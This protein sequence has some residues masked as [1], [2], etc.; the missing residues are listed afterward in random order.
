MKKKFPLSYHDIQR[1]KA[2]EYERFFSSLPDYYYYVNHLGEVRWMTE[3]EAGKQHEFFIYDESALGRWRRRL[4]VNRKIPLH[5]LSDAEREVRLRIRQYLAHKNL[6]KVDP[7]LQAQIPDEWKYDL[8]DEYLLNIPITLDIVNEG[9]WKKTGI[10]IGLLALISIIAYFTVAV[11][12][13]PQVGKVL[14]KTQGKVAG[15][16]VYMDEDIFLG[17]NNRVLENIPVGMHRFYAYKEG[18]ISLPKYHEVNIL[19]DSLTTLQ[20]KFE[21]ARSEVQGYLKI[22]ADLKDSKVFVDNTYLG[23]LSKNNI[24]ALEEGQHT[25]NVQKEGYMTKPAEKVV[26]IVVGDTSFV[27]LTQSPLPR[28][29]RS[30]G[31]LPHSGIGSIEITSN[32]KNARIYLNGKDTGY[33][34]DYIFT[35]F[36]LGKYTV[37]VKKD[38]FFV[39][40]E[41]IECRL[42]KRNPVASAHFRLVRKYERVQIV[43]NPEKGPI[44]IDDKFMGEGKFEGVLN[45]GEH[46]IHFG[47]IAG[48]KTPRPRKIT[49]SP[50]ARAT[51][52][53][54]YF[55]E[56]DIVASIDRSGRIVAKSCEVHTGYTSKYR[57]FTPS[58][59][60]GPEIEF[61]NLTKEYLMVFGFAFPY[62][63]PKGNDAIRLN[64]N[65]PENKDVDQKFY[66]KIYAA[67]SRKKY[68]FVFTP[69]H[70]VEILVKINDK[71]LSTR[72]KP[73]YLED[74]KGLAQT[75]WEITPFIQ[76]GL[77]TFEVST[78]VKNT[79]YF[80]L[81]RIEIHN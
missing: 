22:F 1:I 36:P 16:R 77:N 51:L 54:S 29:S 60:G 31:I 59:E 61:N 57:A 18:Y 52:N 68:P 46:R 43:T 10:V 4:R 78:T 45:I 58:S 24:I 33:Q 23:L 3:E 53:V 12:N 64:F 11:N 79:T 13:K 39:E 74:L 81:K 8:D 44:F 28:E 49:V 14:V 30:R 5:K 35:Q 25:V 62:R 7:E 40:P 67:T 19:Q 32:M 72:Y 69:E 66:V 41:K 80:Y 27:Y 9:I 55:P 65:L 48:Y 17:Y 38:G 56:V 63:N 37:Q 70:H 50:N 26:N 73:Q 15:A 34:T 71:V 42:D 20:F 75:E 21:R 2:E 47:D 6:G 76:P